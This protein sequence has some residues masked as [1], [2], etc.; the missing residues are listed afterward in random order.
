[1]MEKFN[2]CQYF[3]LQHL[4]FPKGLIGLDLDFV[5]MDSDPTLAVLYLAK[6]IKREV[7]MGIR[8]LTLCQLNRREI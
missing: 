4:N 6:N 1:M 7:N 3:Q 5:N 2:P 8:R